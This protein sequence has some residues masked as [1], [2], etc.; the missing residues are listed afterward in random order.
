MTALDPGPTTYRYNLQQ[1]AQCALDVQTACNLSGVVRAFA[2]IT[3]TLWDEARKGG[4]GTDFVNTHPISRL[5]AEQ[6]SHLSGAG[7]GDIDTYTVAARECERLARGVS[8]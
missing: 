5:F 8:S 6:I 3:E 2:A 1:A 4:R 7:M